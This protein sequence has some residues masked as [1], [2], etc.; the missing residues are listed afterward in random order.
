MP[1][2]KTTQGTA[3]VT[4]PPVSPVLDPPKQKVQMDEDKPYGVLL[5]DDGKDG[6]LF[7][8]KVDAVILKR[9]LSRAQTMPIEE[10]VYANVVK[11]AVESHVY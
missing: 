3:P 10:Y 11:P 2:N 4:V 6:A 9:L 1:T 7:M 8:F 5:L